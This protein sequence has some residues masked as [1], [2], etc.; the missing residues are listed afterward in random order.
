MK[1]RY[2]QLVV[3]VYPSIVELHPH[4]QGAVLSLVINRGNSF[5]K[6]SVESRLEMRE[7]AEA[8]L[9]GAPEKIPSR[10]RSMKRLWEGRPGLNELVIR[11]ERERQYCLRRG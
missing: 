2:A 11:R 7:I 10:L 4:C 5:T 3:D 1:A 6:P 9:E 8:L